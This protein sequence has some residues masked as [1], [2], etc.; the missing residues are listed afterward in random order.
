M[1]SKVI[2]KSDEACKRCIT[3]LKFIFRNSDDPINQGI[4]AALK[5]GNAND[6]AQI[7]KKWAQTLCSPKIA[8]KIT[9]TKL[10]AEVKKLKL[11]IKQ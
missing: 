2:K 5:E 6:R 1:C 10:K 8:P 4:T 11:R 9:I 7:M 3:R